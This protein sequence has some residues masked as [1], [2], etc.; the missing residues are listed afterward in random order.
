MARLIKIK[1]SIKAA[2]IT[3]LITHSYSISAGEIS[4]EHA[5]QLLQDKNNAIAAQ[6][7]NV[8]RYKQLER[9]KDAL[10]YPTLS[11][12]ANYTHLDK[13]VTV[14]GDQ[15]LESID[16]K[17]KAAI[18]A[19]PALAGLLGSL[20]SVNPTSTIAHQDFFSSSIRAIWPIFTGGRIT[21]A[22]AIA[23]GQTDQAI[24]QL[25]METQAQYEDLSKYYFS[26]VLARDVLLTRESV[27]KGL[28]KHRDFAIKLEK[29]GQI[30]KVE[31]LQAEASLA[32]AKVDRKKAQK[33]VEIAVS[34]LTQILNQSDKVYPNTKLFINHTLPPLSAFTQQTLDTY[35]GLAILDAKNKQASN[36]IKAEQGRY[37]PEVYL[38]GNYSLHEDDSLANQMT[39]D[40]LVGVGVKLPLIDNSGRS[41]NIQ[42]AQSAVLQV[43]HLRQQATQDL[44][45]LVEKTYF[46]AEQAIEEVEG[47]NA[48]IQLAKENL[49]LRNKA[50]TQ[51]LSTSLEVVDAELYL[52][53]VKTQ[54]QLASF[55]YL[56]A[57]NKL[58]ALASDINAFKQYQNNA[59]Q[60]INSEDAS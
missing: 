57:L 59:Y 39:P 60:P 35:P 27:E 50:F 17:S 49:K 30:A 48:S 3:S 14:S 37:Y 4:F 56:I 28:T 45:V 43:N 51:G 7:A 5:W 9:S 34:A 31:R 13:D 44:S 18:A 22:Q 16:S 12:G 26:V 53:G 55:N 10:N 47:L 38:Y 15:L 2:L 46:E 23:S 6:K 8:Q 21:S 54:Q 25:E 41:E 42:A 58:L 1:Q 36:L 32:K 20:G 52:A 19:N 33:D 11:L 24:A 40:W 29:Q